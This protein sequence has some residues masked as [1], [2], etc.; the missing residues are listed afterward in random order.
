MTQPTGIVF[1]E[2]AELD[3]EEILKKIAAGDSMIG[4]DLSAVN[5][6]GVDLSGSNLYFAALKDADL[7]KANLRSCILDRANLTGATLARANL[8][9]A[10]LEKANLL[11]ANLWHAKLEG[12]QWQGANLGWA[13]FIG[14]TYDKMTNWP[15]G[16]DPNR[17]GAVLVD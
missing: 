1:E 5:F 10:S 4:I 12:V 17:A 11:R 15:E 3:L 13:I 8:R 14:A 9:G 2:M 16:F 7:S 6:R